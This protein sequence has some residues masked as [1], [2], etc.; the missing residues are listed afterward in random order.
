MMFGRRR[1][2][3]SCCCANAVSQDMWLQIIWVLAFPGFG[4]IDT[5]L[6]QQRILSSSTDKSSSKVKENE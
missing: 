2:R 5:S 1:R 3:R 4:P 6:F